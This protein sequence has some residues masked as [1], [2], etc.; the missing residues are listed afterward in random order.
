MKLDPRLDAKI[1]RLGV[2]EGIVFMNFA[3]EY[4]E[5]FIMKIDPVIPEKF[6]R[7]VFKLPSNPMNQLFP[8][9]LK[10]YRLAK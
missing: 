2:G 3:K 7:I 6:V 1:D 5:P 10:R 8:D 4:V 9:A